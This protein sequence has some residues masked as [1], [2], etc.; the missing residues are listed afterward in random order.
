AL[1]AFEEQEA[2]KV[3]PKPA[4]AP[5]KP[6]DDRAAKIALAQKKA[7]LIKKTRDEARARGASQEEERQAVTDA[8]KALAA[9]EKAGE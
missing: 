6:A 1:K 5:A 3:E 4:E 7:A 9:E 8:L 2:A